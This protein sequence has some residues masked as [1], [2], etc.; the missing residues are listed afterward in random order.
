MGL[1]VSL[2]SLALNALQVNAANAAGCA[3]KAAAHYRVVKPQNLEDLGGVIALHGGDAHLAHDGDD[4]RRERAVIVALRFLCRQGDCA[5]RHEVSDA[6]VGKVGMDSACGVAHK[7]R[8]V[9]RGDSV[10]RLH[11]EIGLHA[12]A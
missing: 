2:V 5:T 3:G 12:D 10:S 9:M 7:R 4:A 6:V 11:H 8:V 1:T